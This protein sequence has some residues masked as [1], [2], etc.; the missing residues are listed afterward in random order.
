MRP[1]S[2]VSVELLLFNHGTPMRTSTPSVIL[3]H[4]SLRVRRDFHAVNLESRHAL[5]GHKIRSLLHLG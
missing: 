1:S 5:A 4:I 3:I 2:A